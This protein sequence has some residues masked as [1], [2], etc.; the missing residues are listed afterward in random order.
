MRQAANLGQTLWQDL[1]Q[2]Y[3]HT[4]THTHLQY[5]NTYTHTHTHTHTRINEI[6]NCFWQRIFEAS[7]TN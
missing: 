4:N 3:I 7:L 2:T 5:M 6:E 1:P